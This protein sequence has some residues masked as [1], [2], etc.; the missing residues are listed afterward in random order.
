V[1]GEVSEEALLV[2]IVL[3][4]QG[5]MSLS[6]LAAT[7]KVTLGSMSQT[8]LAQRPARRTHRRRTQRHP[9][10]HPAPPPHRRLLNRKTMHPVEALLLPLGWLLLPLGWLLR[11]RRPDEAASIANAPGPRPLPGHG[12]HRYRY[13]LYALDTDIDFTQ[14]ADLQAV[15]SAL[16]GHVL[17]SGTLTG[18]RT[19]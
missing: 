2:L 13:H 16:A 18:T 12:T 3:D 5:R 1:E 15:P 14:V 11:S 7:A 6:D 9:P 17:A 19:T 4:K 10:G 8:V